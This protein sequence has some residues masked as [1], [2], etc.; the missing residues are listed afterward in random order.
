[1]EV[2]DDVHLAEEMPSIDVITYATRA[3]IRDRPVG[4]LQ[5]YFTEEGNDRSCPMGE[6]FHFMASRAFV[7][8]TPCIAQDI[9][10][11]AA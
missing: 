5:N 4:I 11:V 2:I 6:E 1:V 8:P 10:S 9:H 3:D 7:L